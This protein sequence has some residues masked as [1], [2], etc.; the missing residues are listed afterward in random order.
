[1]Y[2]WFQST[3]IK[4]I[5]AGAERENCGEFGRVKNVPLT[6]MTKRTKYSY[7]SSPDFTEFPF[8]TTASCY[9]PIKQFMRNSSHQ[10]MN[11]SQLK[12]VNRGSWRGGGGGFPSSVRI[13]WSWTRDSL[14]P[15][16][17]PPFSP[18]PIPFRPQSSLLLCL[19]YITRFALRAK[20][21]VR[22]AWLIKR[23]LCRLALGDWGRVGK[24]SRN[25]V[26]QTCLR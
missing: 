24:S 2:P 10:L 22:L 15:H 9:R 8:L 25:E 18:S 19:A 20:C 4:I 14:P 23:Q 5:L 16:P 3:A 26:V 11:L 13:I 12:S 21:C 6:Q 7:I 1:M 17:S